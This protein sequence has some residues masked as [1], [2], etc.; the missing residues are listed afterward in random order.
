MSEFFTFSSMCLFNLFIVFYL[1]KEHRT[2]AN[3]HIALAQTD[4]HPGA[5]VCVCLCVCVRVRERNRQTDRQR[6]TERET[7]RDGDRG[8]PTER[9]VQRPRIHKSGQTLVRVHVDQ[10]ITMSKRHSDRRG[11]TYPPIR[12]SPTRQT[13]SG[14]S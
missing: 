5:R 7:E 12:L 10:L 9:V 6:H 1:I 14:A 2:K 11:R 4:I 13:H 3:T 8:G